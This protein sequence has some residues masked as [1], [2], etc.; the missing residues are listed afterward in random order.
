LA[1]E[2]AALSAEQGLPHWLGQATA[3][4]GWVKV[5]RGD[6]AEGIEEMRWGIAAFRLTGAEI[7]VTYH[8]GLLAEAYGKAGQPREGLAVLAEAQALVEKNEERFWEAELY[9]LRGELLLMERANTAEIEACFH[10]AIEIARWQQAKSLELRAVMSLS[11]LWQQQG[12]T[13]AARLMLAE[14]YGS[15]AEG[16]DTADLKDA[17]AWL[18][19]RNSSLQRSQRSQRS[20]RKGKR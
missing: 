6:F 14:L 13:A 16:F 10:Q 5:E 20:Q 12:K 8:L 18:S 9:R 1:E 11:R 3:G 2:G 19:Q 15:F 17:K 7:H 4:R